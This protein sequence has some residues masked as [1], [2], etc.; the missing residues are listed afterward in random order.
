LCNMC[1]LYCNAIYV[2]HLNSF[3]LLAEVSFPFLLAQCCFH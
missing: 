1:R 3:F 2:F